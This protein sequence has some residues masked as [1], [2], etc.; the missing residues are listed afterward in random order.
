MTSRGV[1]GALH[2]PGTLIDGRYRLDA[3]VGHGM[4]GTVFRASDLALERTVAIKILTDSHGGDRTSAQFQSEARTLAQVRHD[5][6]VQVY[7]VGEHDGREFI[8]MEF[9]DGRSLDT[10][11]QEHS[12]KQSTVSFECATGMVRRLAA[13]LAAVHANGLV[14]RDVKPSNVMVET[15]SGRPVLI[16]F[17][18][19]RRLAQWDPTASRI[20]GTP[21]YMA[22]EQVSDVA[23]V[24]ARSDIYALGC[25]AFE[26]FTGRCVFDADDLMTMLNAHGAT[27]PPP[28]SRYSPALVP[29]DPVFRCALEKAPRNR[30]PTCED[31][32]DAFDRAVRQIVERKERAQRCS[33]LR[34]EDERDSSRPRMDV[35]VLQR[36]D[37]LRRNVVRIVKSTL[38]GAGDQLEVRCIQS[39]HELASAVSN[40]AG[41]LV[42]ID[43]DLTGG[44][45]AE[46]VEALRRT[47][48][49]RAAEIVVLA[50]DESL[51]WSSVR[52]LGAVA[53]PKPVNMRVLSTVIAR[54]GRKIAERRTQRFGSC[55]E[56]V[57]PEAMDTLRKGSGR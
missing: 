26:L 2:V 24:S 5:D 47:P 38:G 21:C 39:D 51:S 34:A 56:V 19:A 31:F 28:I 9:V 35:T 40:H 1:S 48:S 29:L 16:D 50:R 4:M 3:F 46:L 32:V 6:V 10:I 37:G 7:A 14:H 22:P 43:D 20:G 25:T 53:V 8:V 33:T 23:S 55:S 27:P 36:A 42:V 45:T 54:L 11:I 18:L 15:R 13:G 49:G 12:A 57:P 44:R 30:Y 52:E 17:G 41:D